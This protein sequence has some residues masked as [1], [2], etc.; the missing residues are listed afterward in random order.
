L[1]QNY[2]PPKPQPGLFKDFE[3]EEE[4]DEGDPG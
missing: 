2:I 4:D 1:G 3:A